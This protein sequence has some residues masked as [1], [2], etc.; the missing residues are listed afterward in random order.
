MPSS[1]SP[2]THRTN[3]TAPTRWHTHRH[4]PSQ[5]RR[6]KVSN[7]PSPLLPKTPTSLTTTLQPRNLNVRPPPPLPSPL[8]LLLNPLLPTQHGHHLLPRR[9]PRRRLPHHDR[10]LHRQ[11]RHRQ[12]D[13]SPRHNLVLPVRLRR[14]HAGRRRHRRLPPRHVRDRQRGAAHDADGRGAVSGVV[15]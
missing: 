15:L 12:T 14:R 9:H 3:L 4:E 13:P 8:Q 2:Q 10:R 5:D 1:S 11:P 6:S 7:P